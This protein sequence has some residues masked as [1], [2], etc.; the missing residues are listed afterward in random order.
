MALGAAEEERPPE[1][2]GVDANQE[3]MVKEA[4]ENSDLF[5]R[6]NLTEKAIA[7]LEKVLQIYP[8]QIEVH[9]RILE[10]SRKGFPERGAVA[11][12]QLA[13]IFTEH[14]DHETASKYQAIA[15]AR[16]ALHEI[17][18]PP[19]P[20]G[21]KVEEPVTPPPAPPAEAGSGN[22]Q[23]VSDSR[24]RSGG[25]RHGGSQ[26]RHRR[27]QFLSTSPL[28]KLRANLRLRHPH[29]P[30]CPNR[31]WNWIS[32]ETWR[33]WRRLVFNPLPPRF[34]N[35]LLHPRRRYRRR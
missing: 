7:E 35:R 12:A 32:R 23:R 14:G 3:A 20:P 24:D 34:L 22:D 5:A 17:P 16:G 29:L 21:K 2:A 27:Q 13:R 26:Q 10:I 15:S 33:P 28:P 8:D 31:Q 30:C 19:P 25:T 11:A 9:R 4:L 18:L 1:P 6:Y